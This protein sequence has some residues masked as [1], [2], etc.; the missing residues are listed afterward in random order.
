MLTP[1]P[2]LTPIAAL[3]SPQPATSQALVV[4]AGLFVLQELVLL[5][6]ALEAGGQY[7]G[8]NKATLGACVGP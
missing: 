5:I 4:A 8:V 1:S 3:C 7:G 2:L 6:L